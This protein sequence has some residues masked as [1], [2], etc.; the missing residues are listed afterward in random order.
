MGKEKTKD[1]HRMGKM[2][3]QAY[4]LKERLPIKKPELLDDIFRGTRGIN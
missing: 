2:K 3:K 1:E 4:D